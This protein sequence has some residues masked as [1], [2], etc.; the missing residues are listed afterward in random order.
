[1]VQ[2]NVGRTR[3]WYNKHPGIIR[4]PHVRHTAQLGGANTFHLLA[5]YLFVLL[6]VTLSAWKNMPEHNLACQKLT[7]GCMHVL[8]CMLV[9]GPREDTGFSSAIDPGQRL[10]SQVYTYC[11]KF[12]PKTQVM[13]SGL[14]TKEGGSHCSKSLP[15]SA[16]K[17]CC[18]CQ[19]LL[20]DAVNKVFA[21]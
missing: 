4:D 12:H 1:M 2:P 14:R 16:C 9:Q 10:A 18:P 8:R 15:P 20:R 21:S 19:Q 6:L 13:A 17:L 5:V 3:D 7:A 11:K